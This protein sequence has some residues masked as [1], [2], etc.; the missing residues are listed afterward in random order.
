ML[1]FMQMMYLGKLYIKWANIYKNSH[2][3]LELQ[4]SLI[5][6]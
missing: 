1:Q 2:I 4:Q 6:H 3:P 5:I